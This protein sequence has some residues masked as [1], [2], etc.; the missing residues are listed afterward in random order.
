MRF[1]RPLFAFAWLCAVT[2]LLA[3][4]APQDVPLKQ[5]LTADDVRKVGERLRALQSPADAGLLEAIAKLVKDNPGLKPEELAMKLL[6]LRPELARPENAAKLSKLLDSVNP[7]AGPPPTVPPTIPTMPPSAVE[8]TPP[9]MPAGTPP[10]Q[11]PVPPMPTPG[12]PVVRPAPEPN[13]TPQ[14][15]PGGVNVDGNPPQ[16]PGTPQNPPAGVTPQPP[17][18]SDQEAQFR[19]AAGWWEK[20]VGPIDDSPAIKDMLAEFI[21]GAGTGDGKSPLASLLKDLK[22]DGSTGFKDWAK[23][24]LPKDFKFPDLGLGGPKGLPKLPNLPAA[25]P[26]RPA[27]DF[28]DLGSSW[29]PVALLVLVAAGAFAVFVARPWW[30]GR[31]A[32]ATP[33]PVPGL[34][35]W[36]LDPRTV[37]SREALVRAF[38]YLS[39]LTLG[40]EARQYNHV[41]IAGELR[42]RVPAADDVADELGRHYA[43]ARYTPPGD[44]IPEADIAAARA[45]LCRLAGVP[46]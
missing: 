37:T 43:L 26:P 46:A 44:P 21:K 35:P 15:P 25:A 5:T 28:G 3:A 12:G 33:T 34:G 42:R 8:P 30:T 7:K 23:D 41:T 16:P 18:T 9:P 11:Q 19:A 6:Q 39:V 17:A 4:R 27:L 2:S 14:V 32:G 1:R 10:E 20:N 24:I 40:A 38:D 36:P 13:V 22:G 29:A 45:A 31:T